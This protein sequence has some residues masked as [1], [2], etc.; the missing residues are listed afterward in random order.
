M[1]GKFFKDLIALR[2]QGIDAQ[3][4]RRAFLQRLDQPRG[5]RVLMF[6]LEIEPMRE[7]GPDRCRRLCQI[8][9]QRMLDRPCVPAQRALVQRVNAVL[10]CQRDERRQTRRA[11]RGGCS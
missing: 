6:E 3:I 4:E 11:V 5:I 1:R 10:A 9:R 7:F 8:D 2:L